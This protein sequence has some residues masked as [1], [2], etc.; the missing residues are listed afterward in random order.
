MKLRFRLRKIFNKDF[1]LLIETAFHEAGHVCISKFAGFDVD[2]VT[3][4]SVHP[5][6]GKTNV[7]YNDSLDIVNALFELD[8]SSNSF[9]SLTDEKKSKV[10][11]TTHKLIDSLLGGPIGEARYIA[12]RDNRDSANVIVE[13]SDF[14]MT[15]TIVCSLANLAP[16]YKQTLNRNLIYKKVEHLNE[17]M[18]LD[19]FWKSINEVAEKILNSKKYTL[20]K[21]EIDE[22]LKE[23][24][25]WEFINSCKN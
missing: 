16:H 17:I 8:Y 23:C 15:N 4:D 18:T 5:G 9:N 11:P 20:S 7:N 21:L 22:T 10:I 14:M 2:S 24:K 25:F 12:L 13:H 6:N 3:I 1:D 19:E